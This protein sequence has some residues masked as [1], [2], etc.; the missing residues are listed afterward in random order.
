MEQEWDDMKN[1]DASQMNKS[2]FQGTRFL[3][4]TSPR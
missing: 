4:K 3:Y 2:N 1:I